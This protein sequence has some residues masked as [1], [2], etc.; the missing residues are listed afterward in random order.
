RLKQF[1]YNKFKTAGSGGLLKIIAG[2][3]RVP[4]FILLSI[5]CLLYFILGQM[6]EGLLMLAAMLIVTAISL[7]QELRSSNAIEALQQ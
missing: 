7:Y 1:G 4:M 3:V 6:S 2:I 5:A